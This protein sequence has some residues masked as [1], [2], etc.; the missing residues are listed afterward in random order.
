MFALAAGKARTGTALDN[1][2][3]R[4]EG[5]VTLIDGILAS[6]ALLALA[7]NAALGWW[8]AGPAAGDDAGARG[9]CRGTPFPAGY[10]EARR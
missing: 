3:L 5:R 4:T 6:V 8:W 2:V 9:P 10:P 7:L 1:P